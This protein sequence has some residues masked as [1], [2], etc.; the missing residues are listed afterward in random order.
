MRRMRRNS[1]VTEQKLL[2]GRKKSSA[3][4]Q[5]VL[6]VQAC[7]EYSTETDSMQSH[8][9]LNSD[10][11]CP[12]LRWPDG[13]VGT[14]VATSTKASSRRPCLIHDCQPHGLSIE[15]VHM[16]IEVAG[17]CI[18]ERCARVVAVASS[19]VLTGVSVCIGA[20]AGLP[21]LETYTHGKRMQRRSSGNLRLNP[22]ELQT[23][24][25]THK[26]MT[27]H[28]YRSRGPQIQPQ[29]PEAD[30][31]SQRPSRHVCATDQ[32]RGVI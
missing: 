13:T 1:L 11:C 6:C 14:A 30:R 16:L 21:T 25:H 3:L 22:P 10:R 26:H 17:P 15:A 12:T 23:L 5:Q 27:C 7:R 28:Q 32:G 31:Q 29:R 19:P 8:L 18:S 4:A 2:L 9:S 24:G 20:E